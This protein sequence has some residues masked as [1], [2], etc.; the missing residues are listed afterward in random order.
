M[1]LGALGC[2]RVDIMVTVRDI[3]RILPVAVQQ[4]YKEG[5]THSA[6]E[7]YQSLADN[8]DDASSDFW[9]CA[10][11]LPTLVARLSSVPRVQSVTVVVNPTK[12]ATDDLWSRFVEGADSP[13]DGA[14]PPFLAPGVANIALR[15]LPSTLGRYLSI[16]MEKSG[17]LSSIEQEAIRTCLVKSMKQDQVWGYNGPQLKMHS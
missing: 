3:A 11:K 17:D 1:L 5:Q 6:T 15:Y 14:D 10:F 12:G 2:D 7:F 9:W 4:G 8:R 13:L 16:A